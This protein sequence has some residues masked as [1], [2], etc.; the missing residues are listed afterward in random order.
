MPQPE[1]VA[2]EHLARQAT[3]PVPG[4][5]TTLVELRD[6]QVWFPIRGGIM[7]QIRRRP[8]GYV[9]AVDGIDLDIRQG[10]VLALVG[11]SGSGKTT[12]G[13][14]VVRL[15]KPTGGTD[16][17][18]GRG[19][20]RAQGRGR[21]GLPAARAAHL[22]GPVRDA[23]PEADHPRLRGRA[24]R[25]QRHRQGS[26]RARGAGVRGARGGR[27]A[28]G[29]GLPVPLSRTSSRAASASASSSPARSSS[30]RPWSWPTSRSRCSTSPSAPSSSR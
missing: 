14:V 8:L 22:P 27:P 30:A 16:A 29:L 19:L 6:L 13:R 24:A 3:A 28:A 21:Q 15:T 23:R 18:R 7:D 5:A 20:D 10:E 4:Q 9:H 26:G 11:E 12:T 1:A 25:G 2:T 17:L